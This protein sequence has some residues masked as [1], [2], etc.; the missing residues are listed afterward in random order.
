MKSVIHRFLKGINRRFNPFYSDDPNRVY[1]LQNAR[2]LKRGETGFISRIKGYL[3]FHSPTKYRDP[4]SLLAVEGKVDTTGYKK[5]YRVKI[6]E[7]INLGESFPFAPEGIFVNE[8]VTTFV[9]RPPFVTSIDSSGVSEKFL[10]NTIK[11]LSNVTPNSIEQ[12]NNILTVGEFMVARPIF[13]LRFTEEI[14]ASDQDTFDVPVYTTLKFTEEIRASDRKQEK[15][16]VRD[17]FLTILE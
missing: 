10:F 13:A 6:V 16:A 12:D 5:G 8:I 14:N 15:Q 9:E 1:T 4:K 17:F 3:Q 7:E 11:L 2:L